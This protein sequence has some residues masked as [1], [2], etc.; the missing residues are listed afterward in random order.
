RRPVISVCAVR[1]GAGKSQTTRRVA[2]LV[3]E[4]S[5]TPVVVRHPMPYGDLAAQA[6]QRFATR[7]DLVRHHTTIEEREEYEPHLEAGTVVYAG[8]DYGTILAQAEREADVVLW[9]GG[10]NDFPFYRPD[11]AIVVVDPLRPR[12]ELSDS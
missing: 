12:H 3:H 2:A 4:A 6:V 7:D 5:L 10:N 9:D 8:V 1:T 11:L